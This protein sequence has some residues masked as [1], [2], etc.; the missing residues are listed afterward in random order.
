[1]RSVRWAT[2][3]A[4]LAGL[5][6]LVPSAAAQ[7]AGPGWEASTTVWPAHIAPGGTGIVF[8]NV[9]NVGAAGSTGPVV[10]TDTLP[11]GLIATASG[12]SLAEGKR[13]TNEPK[14]WDCSGTQVVACENDPTELPSLTGGGGVPAYSPNRG[15]FDPRIAIEVTA[16]SGV[17]GTLINHVSVAG[18][19]AASTASSTEPITISETPATFGLENFDVAFSNADG[20]AD[21]QAGSHPYA[22]SF[23][24]AFNTVGKTDGPELGEEIR[25][26]QQPRNVE[27]ELPPGLIGNPSAVPQCPRELFENDGIEE[28]C[29][30]NTQIGV[31]HLTSGVTV[32]PP[33]EP[34]YNL[35]PPPGKPAEFGFT[36]VGNPTYLEGL[37]RTESDNGITTNVFN[38]PQRNVQES[39]VT[40]W[41]NPGDPT[42][43][44]WLA[45]CQ[46]E[47]CTDN[48]SQSAPFLTLPTA[49]GPPQKFTVRMHPWFDEA[50]TSETTVR[51][52]DNE[53]NARGYTG[54]ERL[55]FAP[56]VKV[57]PETAQAD[58]PT[59][60]TAEVTP[61]TGGLL[62]KEGLSSSD[63]QDATV[64]LPEGLVINPGQAAGLSA[65]QE[66]EDGV[67]TRAAPS[68][69]ASS[70]VGTV[71]VDTPLLPDKLLGDVYVLP[72][73]PPE[74]K[75]LVAASADGVNLKLIGVV[76]LNGATGQLTT[77]FEGTPEL[78]FTNFKLTFD[79]GARA[80][81]DSPTQ[82]G[83][84]TTTTDFTSWSSPLVV[85]AFP[86]SGFAITA[87]PGGGP[88]PSSPLPFSP[89]MTAGSTNDQAGGFTGF[90]FLLQ[91]D[92]G[93]QRVEKMQFTEPAGLAG[94]IS[95]VSQCAEP[96]ATHGTCS[97]ASQ[98]GHAVVTAGA[99]TSPLVLPQP[100]AP[101]IPIYLTGPYAGAPFGLSIVTPVI[102]G[103]FNLGTIVTRAKIDV[104]PHTAQ[105]TITTDPLPR[106]IDGVPTDLRAINAVVD[107]P[108]FLF[109]P[110]S[111]SAQAF[112]GAASS[113][114][115]ASAPLSTRFAIGACRGLGFHPLFA[116]S[117]QGVTSKRNGASLIVKVA[118]KQGPSTDSEAN[119]AKVDVSLPLALPSR[120]TTLQKACTEAQF[121]ANPAGCPEASNV[122][123]A[124]AHT[125][126]LP[127]PLTGPAYL[128]SH[129]GA[130]FPDLVVVLQGDGV[131]IELVGNTQIKKGITFSRFES[132]P[133]APISS[134]E[135]KLPESSH[136]VLAANKNLCA[137]TK[138]IMSSKRVT[139]RVHGHVKHL[140]VKVTRSVPETLLMPTTITAQN[141][142]VLSQQTKIAV[143]GCTKLKAK[144]KAKKTAGKSKRKLK[145]K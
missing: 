102:A 143:T 75:L 105:I 25:V 137:T 7:T 95:Q 92:D 141:G 145:K 9:M 130:A 66:S 32:E 138:T 109:N 34:V 43:A 31:V 140:L 49:C 113:Y 28:G 39:I 91:R 52:H 60:L 108:G 135:L 12:T 93:Q 30:P 13:P 64:T 36:I 48:L 3:L 27:V 22:A 82:C 23:T 29:P 61:P 56:T 88:C 129:G 114:G 2:R 14:L 18:G 106:I 84:Y 65:C 51:S 89:S 47:Q 111:C 1:M 54:C 16:E 26:P 104:N 21:L 119:I 20:S 50:T 132:V 122:G 62:T 58:S 125:P 94:L 74:V 69:P 11:S 134:F 144:A 76:H 53:G 78:P 99:G 127:V 116:A 46:S 115:G 142:A 73:N 10:V 42:H 123:T 67:G 107:R 77:K 59:G 80:A 96:Q 44:Q 87:G 126:V 4:V 71:S 97:S 33:G 133:D 100:G 19:G 101:E 85:D 118:S 35:V 120:L 90:S 112:N 57:A 103:P 70:K 40:L 136:S 83:T 72:S 81:L 139:K 8:I 124:V 37:P 15:R 110:T 6:V 131:T 117:T 24:L 68:C 128:V 17:S 38:V 121:A 5:M 55:S 86:T 98:I 41:G 63:I 45:S 79:G